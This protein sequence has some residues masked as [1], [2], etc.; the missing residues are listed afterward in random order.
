MKNKKILIL[1]ALSFSPASYAYLDPGSGSMLVSA[2]VGLVA[3]VFFMLKSFY[4]NL[5]NF[6]RSFFGLSAKSSKYDIVFYSEG[7]NYW[8]TFKPIL[9]DFEENNFYA[10][11]LTSSKDDPGLKMEYK[12]IET[13][14][15]GQSDSAYAYLNLIEANILAMTTP[16]LDVFQIKRSKGVKKYA[17]IHHA[18]TDGVYKTYSF[19]YFDII[20]CSGPH[21]INNIKFIENLRG[22]KEKLL[23]MSGCPYYDELIVK[24]NK[25]NFDKNP[26]HDKSMSILI[27]PTW[28]KNGLLKRFGLSLL[29]PLA[30]SGYALKIR[31]HPQSFIV[32]PQLINELKTSLENFKNV[33]WDCSAD[34]FVSLSEADILISDMSGVIFDFAFIFEK[35]VITMDFEINLDGT[36]SNDFKQEIWE[37][38]VLNRIGKKIEIDEIHDISNT[39]NYLSKNFDY[40]KAEIKKIKNESLF[41][42]GNSGKTISKQL[43]EINSSTHDI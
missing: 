26:N 24:R 10:T 17:Y 39:I 12:N 16:G 42:Y 3:T 41:H 21:Q 34:N 5:I 19:D 35:P 28:D 11:Y 38:G 2:L 1:V 6:I 4:Y 9:D 13:K 20:F 22:I 36:D 30:E 23:F 14:Y 40:Y 31:P 15:I 18:P 8:N 32:E 27:A 29:K 33:S 25:L 43:I 7:K 37:L